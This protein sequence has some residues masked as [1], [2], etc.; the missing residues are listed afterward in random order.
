[1]LM[2]ANNFQPESSHKFSCESCY[3]KCSKL[4]NWKSH[5]LTVKHNA[6]GKL[7]NANKKNIKP[8]DIIF[9]C[10]CGKSFKHNPKITKA[11]PFFYIVQIISNSFCQISVP[12]QTI[13]LS[14]TRHAGLHR[15]TRIIVW[16]FILEFGDQF[17][18][19]RSRTHQT[20]ITL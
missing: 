13:H 17:W 20:H 15:V 6:N 10:E 7:I 1:M 3:F 4:C 14:P 11:R 9:T 5:L 12:T 19:F 2:D 18:P 8:A 16:D